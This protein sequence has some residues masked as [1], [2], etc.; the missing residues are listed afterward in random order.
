[1]RTKKIWLWNEYGGEGNAVSINRQV[2]IKYVKDMYFIEEEEKMKVI[3][4]ASDLFLIRRDDNE[5]GCIKEVE[6]IE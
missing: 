3:K 4:I 5:I 2:L 1:M 6:I